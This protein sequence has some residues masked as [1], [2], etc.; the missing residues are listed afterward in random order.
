M[1]YDQICRRATL[2]ALFARL[3]RLTQASSAARHDSSATD[4]VSWLELGALIS[5]HRGNIGAPQEL[6]RRLIEVSSEFVGR[7]FKLGPTGEGLVAP[8]GLP[9]A[10]LREF[11]CLTFVETVLG[12]ALSASA[13]QTLSIIKVLRYGDR[14]PSFSSRNHF[15]GV[16]WIPSA[17]KYGLLRHALPAENYKNVRITI[18]RKEWCRKL[19]TNPM[20]KAL[21]TSGDSRSQLGCGAHRGNSSYDFKFIPMQELNESKHLREGLIL[22]ILRPGSPQNI[23]A[24]GGDHVSHM[25]FILQRD[26]RWLVRG[27][28]QLKRRVVDVELQ[29]LLNSS[30]KSGKG[31][32]LGLFEAQ[33]GPRNPA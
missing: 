33:G 5:K 2:F 28:S 29:L 18:R 10:T 32:G 27:A 19:V 21:L 16:D 8:L 22:T 14:R 13:E 30:R 7:P 6:N 24:G 11:D 9:I 25:G 17:I 1:V 12:I 4:D 3:P 26:G 31:Y 23:Y 15:A 20:Y